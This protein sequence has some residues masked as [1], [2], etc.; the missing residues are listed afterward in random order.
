M[1][2]YLIQGLVLLLFIGLSQMAGILGSIATIPNV[3]AWYQFLVKPPLTPPDWI[4]G[5]VWG[6]LYTLMGIS[7]YAVWRVG[8]KGKW[9]AL[10]FF[11]IHLIVNTAWSI[12]FFGEQNIGLALG[13]IVLLD[14]MILEVMRR[15]YKH[16]KTAAFLLVPYLLWALFAT[17][18]NTALFFLN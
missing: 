9:R 4:F 18:L 2:T 16:S 10:T 1:K 15:F 12:I 3:D 6:I 5:P 17:Y 11:F 8:G 13:V 14:L 7:A